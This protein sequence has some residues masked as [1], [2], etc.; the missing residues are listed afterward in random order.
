MYA[1]LRPIRMASIKVID[2]VLNYQKHDYL[3]P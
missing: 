2:S 1:G 3:Y